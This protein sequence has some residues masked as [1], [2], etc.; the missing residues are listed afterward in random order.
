MLPGIELENGEAGMIRFIEIVEDRTETYM[1][2]GL[3]H[4]RID[5]DIIQ[6]GHTLDET[7]SNSLKALAFL[8]TEFGGY[9]HPL[10]EY[11]KKMK[12]S[13]ASLYN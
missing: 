12:K 10:D 8:Y 1:D 2:E 6:M 9:E 11:K 5:E 7:R 4:A 3:P 13:G